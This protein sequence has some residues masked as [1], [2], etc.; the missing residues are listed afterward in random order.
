MKPHMRPLPLS[1]LLGC[2]TLFFSC[3]KPKI[4]KAELAARSAAEAREKVLLRELGGRKEETAV[5][6]KQ[7]GELNR[8]IGTQENEISNLRTELSNRTQSLGASTNK[9]ATEKAD[10]EKE[11]N[12]KNI[13]LNKREE[14]L[15][16]VR[17]GQAKRKKIVSDID[18][19]LA[20]VYAPFAETGVTIVAENETV[21]LT[22]PDKALFDANGLSISTSGKNLLM[23]LAEFLATR[24]SLDI[25]V[26]AYT[27]NSLPPKE[28]TLKDTWDWSLQR[29][30][31]LTRLLIREFNTNANQLTPVG[32]GEFYPLTS[33]ETAEGRQKN[34][35]TVIVVRPQL[36]AV[37]SE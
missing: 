24:P 21:F 33:N 18:S 23:P 29:A 14:S 15:S 26:V 13:L 9:L 32:R 2:L 31:N 12:A 7:V 25:D 36:P 6:T 17:E 30:T 3:V 34:R 8:T 27:D 22:L 5:L 11:L 19:A 1:C 4:Y 16:R 10:L 35:R 20:G 37:P 28:K